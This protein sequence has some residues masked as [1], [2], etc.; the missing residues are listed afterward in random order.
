MS[1]V[2]GLHEQIQFLQFGGELSNFGSPGR[3]ESRSE[4]VGVVLRPE[5]GGQYSCHFD[6]YCPDHLGAGRQIRRPPF[7]REGAQPMRIA[8]PEVPRSWKKTE[9]CGR[10]AARRHPKP[11]RTRSAGSLPDHV[12]AANTI[13][14]K[15]NVQ[16]ADDHF[17]FV[18]TRHTAGI[19]PFQDS[20]FRISTFIRM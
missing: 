13:F 5:S 10:S 11:I 19:F 16:K 15:F 2:G 6:A 4:L 18:V 20:H 9:R 14:S 7:A 1:G 3:S 8:R 17:R 12:H